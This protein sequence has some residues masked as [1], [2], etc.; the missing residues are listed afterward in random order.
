MAV[1]FL[2]GGT[3]SKILVGDSAESLS[4]GVI[5]FLSNPEEFE[6]RLSHLHSMVLHEFTWTKRTGQLLSFVEQACKNSNPEFEHIR[7]L[8]DC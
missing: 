2:D 3:I 1:E 8:P 5:Q 6:E 7:P 4:N